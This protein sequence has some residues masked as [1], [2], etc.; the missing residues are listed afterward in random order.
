MRLDEL[1]RDVE[2]PFEQQCLTEQK[3]WLAIRLR[4]EN[5]PEQALRV[6][7]SFKPKNQT[8]ALGYDF[9]YCHYGYELGRCYEDLGRKQEALAAYLHY[10]EL[11]TGYHHGQDFTL[12][13]DNLGGVPLRPDR[14]IDVR[15]AEWSTGKPLYCRVLAT[16]GK[17][18]YCAGGFEQDGGG[19][20]AVGI[21]SVR[22]LELATGEWSSLG[23]PNDRVSCLAIADGQLWA[24]TD[25]QGLWRMNLSTGKWRQW[26]TKDGLPTASVIAVA[27]DGP[28][29]YVSVGNI[30]PSR[31]V[32]SGGMVRVRDD[33]VH[34]YR[35]DDAPLTAPESMTID[36]RW[37][38]ASGTEN[39]L[40]ALEL[41]SDKWSIPPTVNSHVAA[42]GRSG[43]WTAPRGRIATLLDGEFKTVKGFPAA[44]RLPDFQ[45]HLYR[46]KFL[47]EN[48]GSLWIGGQ[49][50]RRFGDSGLF[51]LDLTTGKFTRYGPRDGFRYDDNN[52]YTC[53]AG[54]WAGG[55]LWVATSFG[56]AEVTV[57]PNMEKA[58]AES[59][60]TRN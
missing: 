54:V 28:T 36:G 12:R 6:L 4:K 53:Y 11:P 43:L 41:Q 32:I 21:Q 47:L 27:A 5:Q 40:H 35:D 13:I 44:P 19:P 39:R 22:V 30:D 1:F 17:R 18:L 33:S 51:R 56:L 37:L 23:G 48:G 52:S 60:K 42:S 45:P 31:Q 50:W 38:V 24:G 14:E 10:A 55:Q 25:H 2:T 15:Y 16:E 57:L 49:P 3:T 59:L 34:I 26:T 7:E 8:G 9:T 46:P 58:H 20:R 29:A